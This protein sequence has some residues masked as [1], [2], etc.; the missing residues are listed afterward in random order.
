MSTHLTHLVERATAAND[1]N[2]TLTSSTMSSSEMASAMILLAT[3]VLRATVTD[4]EAQYWRG[5]LLQYPA[6][7]IRWAFL[8]YLRTGKYFPRPA[9]IVELL[10]QWIRDR[11]DEHE[12]QKRRLEAAT[13]ETAR[14]HGDL[15]GWGDVLQR[16]KALLERMA[17]PAAPEGQRQRLKEQVRPLTRKS[18]RDIM[19]PRI[20]PEARREQLRQQAA[21]LKRPVTPAEGV[22]ESI[23]P[24][25]QGGRKG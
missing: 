8:E 3:G 19:E 22:G 9:D 12:A 17:M 23:V 21:S 10:D 6:P 16:C 24:T 1:K 2:E 4:E 15:F 11:R 13:L 20:I 5:T 18:M 14:R 7:A 25:Q